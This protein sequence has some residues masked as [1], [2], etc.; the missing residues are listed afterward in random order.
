M[1]KFASFKWILELRPPLKAMGHS[2]LVLGI[3]SYLDVVDISQLSVR[4]G[5]LSGSVDI[6]LSQG[7][8]LTAIR[9]RRI[10]LTQSQPDTPIDKTELYLSIVE[11]DNKGQTYGLGWTPSGRRHPGAGA[12]A[13]AESSQHISAH[14]E[15]IEL[16]RKD[17]K[18][19]QT[20]LTGYAR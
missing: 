13:G 5:H 4:W 3:G 16:L 2:L 18:E 17:I 14:D 1:A 8:G 20:N 12:G 15:P 7:L 19:M 9:N 6:S 11:R 10:E